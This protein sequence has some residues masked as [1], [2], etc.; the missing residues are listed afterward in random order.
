MIKYVAFTNVFIKY[1]CQRLNKYNYDM[2]C[3]ILIEIDN[4]QMQ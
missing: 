1:Y 2:P 3:K 4:L